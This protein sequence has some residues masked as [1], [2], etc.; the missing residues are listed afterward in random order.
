MNKIHVFLLPGLGANTKIFERLNWPDFVELHPLEWRI[1]ESMDESLNSYAKRLGKSIEECDNVVLLGVSFG[2][3]MV[4]EIAKI[5]PVK[6]VILISSIKSKHELPPSLKFFKETKLYKLFPAKQLNL[7]EKFALKFSKGKTRE[8]IGFYDYYLDKRD[9]LYL[10]WSIE[11]IMNWDQDKPENNITHLQGSKDE[12]F[13]VKYL[14]DYQE[15]KGGG[16]A[17]VL[18]KAKKISTILDKVLHKMR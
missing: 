12:I 2:G 1:P 11:Q 15:I 5:Y 10:N 13:P 9:P 8:R 3:V 14:N 7:I 18:I 17:M 4:Q 6:Q 16:H